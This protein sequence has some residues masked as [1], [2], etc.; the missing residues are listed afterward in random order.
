MKQILTILICVALLVSLVAGCSTQEEAY[1]PT[2]NAL[3]DQA[4]PPTEEEPQEKSLTLTYYRE[5]TLNPLLCTDYTNKVLFSFLYQSLFVVD[6]DYQ[7]EPMLCKSYRISSDMRT[8]TVYLENATFSNGSPLQAEDVVATLLA[9]KESVVY[10]GRFMH[11]TSVSAT[12]D[13]AVEIR[14]DTPFENLPIL[15]DIPIIPATQL[16]SDRPAGT[17]PYLLDESGSI[18]RLRRRSDWWC[19]AEMVINPPSI[20]LLEAESNTQIRDN[21]QFND[22]DLVCADPGS[23]RFADYRCDYELWSC[24]NGMLMYLACSVDSPVFSNPEVRAALTYAVDRDFLVEEYYRGYA[25]A[26]TLPASPSFPYYNQSLAAKY[27]YNSSLFADAVANAGLL[28]AEVTLLL[29]GGDSMRVRVGRSIAEMLTQC[30][31]TVK[32]KELTGSNYDYAV[33]TRQFDLYLGQTILSPN[34]DLSPFFH[35]YG[36]LSF[37]GI[38]DITA[39]SLCL[40]SLANYGNYYSLYKYVMEN[41]SLCPVIFRSYAIFATRGLVTELEPARDN[42]FYYSLGKTMEGALIRGE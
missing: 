28:G 21:F 6:R 3:G 31:L 17:G 25:Q 32:V 10:G 5:Q 8:Y 12:E 29:N 7:V 16:E 36:S 4:G 30:G 13:G 23:D 11:I 15:L 24:E 1:V 34:M 19:E 9:A 35:T 18:A 2:G 40:E 41:G 39:Y 37:G 27:T 42:I 33:R 14:T 38:N 22:L 26:V 20:A